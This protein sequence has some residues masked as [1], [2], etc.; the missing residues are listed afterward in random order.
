LASSSGHAELLGERRLQLL[1][2]VRD[3]DSAAGREVARENLRHAGLE[4]VAGAGADADDVVDRPRIEPR[5]D[6]ITS[7]SATASG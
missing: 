5:L 6:A 3:V 7:A 1:V 4:R 2:L